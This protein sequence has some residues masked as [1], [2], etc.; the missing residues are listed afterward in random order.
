M[1]RSIVWGWYRWPGRRSRAVT[2]H[3]SRFLGGVSVDMP[4]FQGWGAIIGVMLPR[5]LPWAI[6]FPPLRGCV[7]GIGALWPGR[8]S[9]CHTQVSGD[10]IRLARMVNEVGRLAG[11]N[12]ADTDPI[13]LV[14]MVNQLAWLLSGQ[15][16]FFTHVTSTWGPLCERFPR[17]AIQTRSPV[18]QAHRGPKDVCNNQSGA[19][20]C[21]ISPLWGLL[22]AEDLFFVDRASGD[23]ALSPG[24]FD[25]ALAFAPVGKRSLA[26]ADVAVPVAGVDGG[27]VAVLGQG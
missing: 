16:I 10:P 19:L 7:P 11:D 17:L 14:R 2:R 23:V 12:E 22:L 27:Q 18:G 1:T 3:G 13:R 25:E 4:P 6:I 15:R 5:A 8:C 21:C 26:G 24:L 9:R 20:G